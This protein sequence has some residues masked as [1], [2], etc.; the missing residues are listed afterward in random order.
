M[1]KYN[2]DFHIFAYDKTVLFAY[3]KTVLIFIG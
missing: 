1:P 2:S 3:D